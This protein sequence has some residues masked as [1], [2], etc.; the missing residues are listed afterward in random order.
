MKKCYFI[1]ATLLTTT[2]ASANSY[3]E[4]I[5]QNVNNLCLQMFT[6]ES[7]AAPTAEM[8]KYCKNTAACVIGSTTDTRAFANPNYLQQATL[9]CFYNEAQKVMNK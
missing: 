1:L 5:R 9:I 6:E 3:V 2:I 4:G 8:K 7:G